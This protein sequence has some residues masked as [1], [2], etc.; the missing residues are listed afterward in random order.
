MSSSPP[1]KVGVIIGS[2]RHS[3]NTI[4]YCTYLTSRIAHHHPSITVETID[5]INSPGHPLP[6]LISDPYPSTQPPTTLPS[7][8]ADPAIRSW[9]AKILSFDGLIVLAPQYNWGCSATLKNAL[10]QLYHEW[11]GMPTMIASLGSRGGNKV[12]DQL[13]PM[14]QGGLH[15]TLVEGRL[16]FKVPREYMHSPEGRV[17]GDE[18]FLKVYDGTVEEVLGELVILME[19]RGMLKEERKA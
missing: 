12:Q 17:K 6:F 1:Y 11:N 18:E 2:A 3:S 5:L 10:D 4:G 7:A 9:S 14:L 13:R 19:S 8:Y 15:M 16:E